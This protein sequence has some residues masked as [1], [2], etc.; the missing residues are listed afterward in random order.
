MEAETLEKLGQDRRLIFENVANGVP[1]DQV[2]RAFRRSQTDVDRE[3]RFVA[4][5]IKEARFRT[6]MPPL[7]CDDVRDMRW[8]RF[9]LLDTLRQVSDAFLGTDLTLPNIG[10]QTLDSE[11]TLRDARDHFRAKMSG[12]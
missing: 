2:R 8:N 9:A 7:A 4:R 11:A 10:V 5:K 3:L 1:M 6:Y 12:R